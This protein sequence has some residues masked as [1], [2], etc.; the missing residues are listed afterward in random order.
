MNLKN[1]REC[2]RVFA[3]SGNHLCP[4][5][6]ESLD[7]AFYKVREYLYKDPDANIDKIS[8]DTEVPR[9]I[10]LQMLREGRLELKAEVSG[11]TCRSCKAPISAGMYCSGCLHDT[12]LR[13]KGA[14]TRSTKEDTK[15]PRSKVQKFHTDS[16]KTGREG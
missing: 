15:S 11:L 14:V 8:E 7:Q 9:K 10:I 3:F 6:L 13:L 5:C 2:G 1:C 4:R 16:R 12:E